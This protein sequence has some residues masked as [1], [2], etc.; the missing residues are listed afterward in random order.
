MANFYRKAMERLQDESRTFK[1][2]AQEFAQGF[3]DLPMTGIHYISGNQEKFEK[4]MKR[5]EKKLPLGQ[6]EAPGNETGDYEMGALLSIPFV[7]AGSPVMLPA[8][9]GVKFCRI[10]KQSVHYSP[11][12]LLPR[13][14][15]K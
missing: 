2:S 6:R 11:R 4:R 15:N 9:L 5:M 14:T 3:S 12:H 10:N 13:I 8:I 1:E 7:V